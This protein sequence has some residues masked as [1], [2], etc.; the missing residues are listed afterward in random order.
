MEGYY[1]P[2]YTWLPLNKYKN[3]KIRRSAFYH[4][5][6]YKTMKKLKNILLLSVLFCSFFNVLRAQ[7]IVKADKIARDRD[8]LK[9][10]L[11]MAGTIGLPSGLQYT[12]YVKG[13]GPKPKENNKVIIGYRLN[14]M[15]G[16]TIYE[17]FDK[18]FECKVSDLLKGMQEG[19][20]LMPA[21]STWLFWIPS[22]LCIDKEGKNVGNGRLLL[23]YVHLV[24]IK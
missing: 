16:Q 24:A 20:K 6:I 15:D 13:N 5:Q 22:R 7:D 11:H 17:H 3:R 2:T 1:W 4:H 19:V 9:N 23:A 12:L 21:G 18:P 10:N 8:L 14:N